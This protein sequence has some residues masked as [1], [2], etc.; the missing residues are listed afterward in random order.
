MSQITQL[1]LGLLL[2]GATFWMFDDLNDQLATTKAALGNAQ[3]ELDGLRE[4]AR[5]T[6]ERLATAAANDLKHTQELNHALDDIENLRL[7]VDAGNQRLHVKA[8][9][10][11]TVPANSGA[12][13]LADAGTAELAADA[14]SDYFT[15]RDQLAL[16]RQM[17]L[18]LQD[19]L[20]SFCTTTQTPTGAP[21]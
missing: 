13:G 2:A 1:L 19:H 6:G 7:A 3:Y 10:S 17:I 18:G 11:A 4:S 21:K 20:R 5:I 8:T 14:R 15:L 9:C 12:A 16:S